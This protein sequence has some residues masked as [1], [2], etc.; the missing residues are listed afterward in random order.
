MWFGSRCY[1]IT[2]PK[3]IRTPSGKIELYSQSLADAGYDPIPVFKE[4]TQSPVQSPELSEK[5]P[6]ILITGSRIVEYTHFQMRN[7]ES[8]RDLAPDPVVELHPD[9]ARNYGIEDGDE[10]IVETKSQWARVKARTT[11]DIKSGVASILHGWGGR[12]NAN[13]LTTLE[14]RDPVTGYPE[15]KALACRIRKARPN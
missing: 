2:A 13:V 12:G 7:V 15:M 11:E 14:P 5:Y 4:P 1:D 8:L 9:T 6:L 3:Q 10:V